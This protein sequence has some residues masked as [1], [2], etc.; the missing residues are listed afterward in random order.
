MIEQAAETVLLVDQSK[1]VTHGRQA[2]ASLDAV[3]LVLADGLAPE[4]ADRVRSGGV[5]VRIVGHS[6][7]ELRRD[8]ASR[9]TRRQ[10]A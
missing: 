1:L 6:N 8:G 10:R 5:T 9:H 7:V 2:I 3:S 4:E